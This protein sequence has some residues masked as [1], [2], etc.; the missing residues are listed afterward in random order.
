[1]PSSTYAAAAGSHTSD[2]VVVSLNPRMARKASDRNGSRGARKRLQGPHGSTAKSRGPK[3]ALFNLRGVAAMNR[4][5]WQR[6][7]ANFAHA[8][9]L[10]PQD[11]LFPLNN[12]GRPL[13]DERAIL[14]TAQDFYREAQSAPGFQRQNRPRDP[15]ST[16]RCTAGL[17]SQRK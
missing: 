4:N 1:M 12:P 9:K 16:R 3:T 6:A 11:G 14:E 5:D 8:Y 13:R 7:Q 2:T 17:G 10:S 15:A